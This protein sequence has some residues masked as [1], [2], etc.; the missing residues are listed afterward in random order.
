MQ[1]MGQTHQ[2][3]GGLLQDT[4]GKSILTNTKVPAS[5]QLM[6]DLYKSELATAGVGGNVGS[7]AF[8]AISDKLTKRETEG[9]NVGAYA[10]D[11]LVQQM[12]NG[13]T[14]EISGATLHKRFEGFMQSFK[15]SVQSYE[16][17][18]KTLNSQKEGLSK[19]NINVGELTGGETSKKVE[20]A[21]GDGI[22]VFS[23][24]ITES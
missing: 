11:Q 23:K 22:T 13:V 6:N 3:Y 5:A 18:D 2:A 21:I 19:L 4:Y 24:Q 1:T 12:P 15:A 8:K 17:I 7:E 20:Q 10:I 16:D 9:V 14:S